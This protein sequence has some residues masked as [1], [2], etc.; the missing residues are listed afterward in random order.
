[1]FAT[2][3][4]DGAIATARLGRYPETLLAGLPPERRKRFFKDGGGSF[5]VSNQIRELCTFST[6]NLV[7]DPPFR[8]IDLVSCRNLLI[9]LGT[10]LQAAILPVFHY[11]LAPRGILLLGSSESASKH[12]ELFA[13]IDRAARIFERLDTT[14]PPLQLALSAVH[15]AAKN[16]RA[17]GAHTLL[18]LVNPDTD[19]AKN[20]GT[21]PSQTAPEAVHVQP[22]LVGSTEQLQSL[23][24]EHQTT[25]EELRSSNEELHSVNEEMQSTNE[26]LQTAKEEL[27]AV[28]EELNTVNATLSDKVNALDEINAD[29]RNLFD[30]T[31]VAT[32]F[33]DNNLLIR[34]FTPAVSALY[35]LIPSDVGRPLSDIVSRLHYESLRE[36][37]MDVLTTLEQLERRISRE[38]RSMHYLMRI[39]P[40]RAPDSSVNGVVIT[41][42]DVTSIVRAEAALREADVR[43]DVFLATLSHEL[44]N[45]LAPIRT[46]ARLLSKAEGNPAILARSEA[47]I[48]RQVLHMSTLLDDLL[49]VSRISHGSF[50]LKKEYADIDDIIDTAVEAVQPAVDAKRHTLRIERPVSKMTL[51]VDKVRITQVLSNLLTNA[52]KYTS[53]GGEITV[54]VREGS[55]E[56]N[57]FVR[58]NGVGI[59]PEALV[60]VFAMFTQVNPDIDRSEGGLGIGLAL[61]KGLVELHGGRVEA[62]S[63]G[64]GKGSEFIVSLPS[65]LIVAM[66]RER[67][68][69]PL[70]GE[71]IAASRRVL[72]ADDNRDGAESL[73]LLLELAGHEVYTAN[74]GREALVVAAKTKPEICI[75]DIGMPG[76]SGYEVAKQIRHEAWGKEITLI[77]VTGWGQDNDKRLAFASGFDHHFTKPVD[78][79]RLAEVFTRDHQEPPGEAL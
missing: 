75:L 40:Y 44:R 49:D 5:K 23:A 33:V 58:D 42:L 28:N 34:S 55:G 13:P 9:Y 61:V 27:Q 48:S 20:A 2:D 63:D 45:P 56:P 3:I 52:T 11:A 76:L 4:D 41:F 73:G 70:P 36:D 78:P 29:L 54:G 67:L 74:S 10:E 1:M 14:S 64:P 37:V 16:A 30:S 71:A 57:I 68:S 60:Q 22:T 46:A 66:P 50:L 39:M 15:L 53:E 25:L 19:R 38:D 79:E 26:E 77:A 32:I 24:E 62:R 12:A 31:Q 59:A 35:H 47:I 72:I 69:N 7:R 6:H 65:T 21:G 17:E 43:K 51:E 8:R 18:E